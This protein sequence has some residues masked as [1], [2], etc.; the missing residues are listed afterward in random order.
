MLKVDLVQRVHGS[1]DPAQASSHTELRDRLR[2]LV[3]GLV[4]TRSVREAM[5]EWRG[6]VLGEVK[7]VIKRVRVLQFS[8]NSKNLEILKFLAHE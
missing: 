1:R 5:S 2:P 4:R 8:I 7:G 3:L 6:V